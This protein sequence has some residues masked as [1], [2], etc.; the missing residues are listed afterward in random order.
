VA[1][2]G[3]ATGLPVGVWR[4]SG[5]GETAD[6]LSAVEHVGV[7]RWGWR[8][9]AAEPGSSPSSTTRSS[10]AGEPSPRRAADVGCSRA[11]QPPPSTCR[12][13]DLRPSRAVGL[14]GRRRQSLPPGVRMSPQTARDPPSRWGGTSSERWVADS[15]PFP[16]RSCVVAPWQ[17]DVHS[18]N[19]GGPDRARRRSAGRERRATAEPVR[20]TGAHTQFSI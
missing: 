13:S 20:P 11:L 10:S 3:W 7:S 16:S 9:R 17:S 2:A 6:D 12:R 4:S 15:Q 18:V 8:R 14:P 5:S 19:P 1:I